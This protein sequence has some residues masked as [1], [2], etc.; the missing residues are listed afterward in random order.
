M[1]NGQPHSFQIIMEDRF[2]GCMLAGAIG[3]AIGA[4]CE[5]MP[6]DS[7]AKRYG[8]VQ[9]Y[10]REEDQ[11]FA[12]DRKRPYG[13]YT[14]D[15]EMT[16]CLAQ[17]LIE[18]KGRV[19]PATMSRVLLENFHEDRGYSRNTLHIVMGL[20]I[21]M[22]PET[23]SRMIVPS[24]EWKTCDTY[25]GS[26]GNGAAMRISPLGL[27]VGRDDTQQD[28]L[29]QRVEKAVV[30]TH[31]NPEA[32]DAAFILAW[33]VSQLV[34]LEVQTID[35]YATIQAAQRLC[36]TSTLRNKL[37]YIMSGFDEKSELD[38]VLDVVMGFD[39]VTGPEAVS[40]ALAIFL[41]SYQTPKEAVLQ[42]VNLG[43]DCDTTAGMVGSL[44]GALHGSSWLPDEWIE[45]L[46]EKGEPIICTAK[47][48]FHVK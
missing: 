40:V 19:V 36:R 32:V 38:D 11:V 35:A 27:L 34:T 9:T 3:D 10:I 22:D 2:V 33:V 45:S 1:V 30:I 28:D 29:Y 14:D 23:V 8:R 12:A 39:A 46:E 43:G 48:L 7:I 44:M 31:F 16:L 15:T 13:H 26:N 5:M 42:A 21:G 47:L 24:S 18:D 37:T 6:A 4:G 17:A 20:R 41:W 25:Q